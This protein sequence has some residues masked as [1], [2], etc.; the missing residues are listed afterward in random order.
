MQTMSNWYCL[1]VM[2]GQE[3][4]VATAAAGI[5]GCKSSAPLLERDDRYGRRVFVPLFA[6]YVFVQCDLDR[7]LYHKL[8]DIDGVIKLLDVS[9]GGELPEPIPDRDLWWIDALCGDARNGVIGRSHVYKTPS[10]GLIVRDGILQLFADYVTKVCLRQHYVLVDLP[11][12]N[13]IHRLRFAVDLVS[14]DSPVA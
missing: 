11:V 12:G 14:P 8:I 10:G 7:L 1:H 6:G 13:T 9:P 4:E 2:S 3:Q 5:P